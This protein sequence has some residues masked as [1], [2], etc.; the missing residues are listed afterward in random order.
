MKRQLNCQRAC[1]MLPLYV[2]G[3]LE[4][5]RTREVGA[6]LAACAECRR[7]AAEFSESRSLLAEACAT[8]EFSAEFYAGIR[9]AVLD[10]VGR[11]RTTPS[12][13]SAFNASP[14][15]ASLF[16]RR[17][18]YAASFAVALIALA[19]ALQHARH[20]AQHAPTQLAQATRDA[21]APTPTPNQKR[22]APSSLLPD[23]AAQEG[24]TQESANVAITPRKRATRRDTATR[25]VEERAMKDAPTAASLVATVPRATVNSARDAGASSGVEPARAAVSQSA[26]EVA[27]IEIQTSDP[28]IRIIWLAPPPS[29]KTGEPETSP[30]N[31]ENPHNHE[32]GDRK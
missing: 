1:E 9:S 32:N 10:R 31:R 17:L 30:N 21:H 5:T 24:S 23:D 20:N 7:L 27:R 18:A 29:Q 3:D 6:H 4:E 26:P 14:F 12:T 13:P 8:P 2:A 11:D 28:N 19:L 22:D 25:Q 15:I 16:G